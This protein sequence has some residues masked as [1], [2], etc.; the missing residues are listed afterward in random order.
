MK[1]LKYIQITGEIEILS[2]LHIGAGNDEIHIGGIDSPVVKN[3]VTHLPYIPGSSLKGKM[4]SLLELVTGRISD[5]KP[6]SVDSKD[7]LCN[8][9][10]NGTSDKNYKGGH[11]RLI[12]RDCNLLNS[13]ILREKDALTEGKYEVVIDRTTGKALPGGLRQIERVPAG[14]KFEFNLSIRCFEGD[15]ESNM[16]DFIKQGL[17]LLELDAIGGCGSRGYGKIR[18]QDLKID[19]TDVNLDKIPFD[20]KKFQ[21]A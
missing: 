21:K 17:K 7:L 14:A 12:F 6:Y 4:R 20:V 2:G 19:G 1:L 9:F 16:I 3:P 11:T 5:G 8:L 18:F 15:E 13:T 10:G